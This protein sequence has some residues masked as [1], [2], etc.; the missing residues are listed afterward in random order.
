MIHN[1]CTSALSELDLAMVK[2]VP[3]GG[4]WKN[5]P[6][7]IPSKRL[8]QI[9][10]GFK[11]GKGSRST[12]YG[13]M[14]PDAPAYTIS[15]YFNRPGNGCFIH[16]DFGGAQHRMISLR[17]AA[18]LQSFPD[19]FIF[20]G[21]KTS[22]QKQIGNAVPPLLAYQV[23][24]TIDQQGVF[25][26]LFSGAGGLSKGFEWAGW[27][28]VLAN[29]I[30]KDALLTYAKN[31]GCETVLGDI[32]NPEVYATV[33]N[34]AKTQFFKKPEVAKLV[35]GGPPCQGFSTA[36]NSR[37]MDDER[38]HLFEQY[39]SVLKDLQPDA[40]V[41]EN[42]MGL[43]SMQSGKVLKDVVTT[44]ESTGYAVEVMELSAEGYGVPQRRKR[45][46][47]HGSRRKGISFN[48]PAQ[49]TRAWK[50]NVEVSD[51]MLKK[52]TTAFEALG[53]LPVLG[54]NEDGSNR[55]YRF[56]AENLYQK[57]MRQEASAQ[58]FVE[59][60]ANSTDDKRIASGNI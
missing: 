44:L 8:Q 6:E 1:H 52:A 14:K 40:F 21:S 39:A 37:S 3:P 13:R 42:V 27:E 49:I 51:K 2:A 23:A 26:D 9:R 55:N 28:P 48:M 54:A 17:E 53:D 58:S 5:I 16:Y 50:N 60:L 31:H 24:K 30:D 46:F 29:D 41:F 43:K 15:T 57:L 33:I 35:V 32:R 38:N 12:Y 11:A 4:N 56:G 22:I 47:I 25:V 34:N 19:N 10:E 7:S 45:V 36:G 59:T 20:L 18:R